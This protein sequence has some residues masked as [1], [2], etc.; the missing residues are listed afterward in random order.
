MKRKVALLFGGRG[1]EHAVSCM[2]G[3]SIFSAIENEVDLLPIAI[4]RDGATYLYRDSR[5]A[6]KNGVLTLEHSIPLSLV[7]QGGVCGALTA[8]GFFPIEVALPALHGDFGEDGVVQGYLATL[9]IP[10]VG[11]PTLGGA[12]ANDKA[13]TKML[14]ATVGVP[15]LKGCLLSPELSFADAKATVRSVL[16]KEYPYF[17]KPNARGSSVG[18]SVAKDDASL[19]SAL[20]A[21][22]VYGEIL[23]EPYLASIT[24]LEIGYLGVEGKSLLTPIGA[25][26]S[27][28]GFYD[29]KEKY[30]SHTARIHYATSLD[31]SV[32]SAVRRHART[33]VRL[34]GVRD[35]CRID[36]FLCESGELYFNEI[37]PFPGFTGESLYPILAKSIGYDYKTLLLT[38]IEGAYARGI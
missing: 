27:S 18:A 38:L 5:D 22:A 20:A 26:S 32:A 28:C 21:A 16:G 2:S 30:S 15:T 23:I 8:E 4:D 11:T 3:A 35:L 37:N 19:R 9:G 7:R 33:L 13:I 1:A 10:F 34:L 6:L 25:I 29:Y 12:I 14:A 31:E 36:F 17:V 24:E